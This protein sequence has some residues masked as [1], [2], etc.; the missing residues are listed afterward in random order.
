MYLNLISLTIEKR[1]LPW[2]SEQLILHPLRPRGSQSGREKR[3]DERFQ[4]MAEEPPGTDS[5]NYFQKFKRIPA[6]DWAQKMLCIIVPNRRT[7]SP[8]FFS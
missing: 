3:R 1:S 7:V 5:P 8:E 6:P 4:V 2:P